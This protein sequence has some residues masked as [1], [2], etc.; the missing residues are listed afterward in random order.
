MEKSSL[1]RRT[2]IRW[3]LL[4][5]FF[6]LCAY[7]F[8]PIV[9]AYGRDL[10][11]S[12]TMIGL[13]GGAY[14]LTMMFLR[15]PTGLISDRLGK[16]R[17]FIIG[18]AVSAM[19][20]SAAVLIHPSPATLFICRAFCGLHASAWVPFTVLYAASYSPSESSRAMAVLGAVYSGAQ[21]ASMLIGGIIADSFGYS[22]PFIL[23]LAGGVAFLI[24]SPM[25][26]DT[27]KSEKPV[28]ATEKPA[29][30]SKG[31]FLTARLVILTLASVIF[32]YVKYATA[33]TFTPLIAKDLGASSAALGYLS[34]LY[35][36]CGIIGSA[37][38]YKLAKRLGAGRV[39][40]ASL[41]IL[42]VF[43]CF[44]VP[45]LTSLPILYITIGIS[46]LFTFLLDAL[47]AGI[48]I[49]GVDE[50]H[51][52]TTMGFYQ[53]LYGM[54]ILLGPVISGRIIDLTSMPVAYNITGVIALVCAAVVFIYDRREKIPC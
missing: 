47:L 11:A 2:M 44:I 22:A 42:A 31:S 5:L 19:L 21:L 16:R 7:P 27:P 18:G 8:V 33:Y 1:D 41:V 10:G 24:C 28:P 23:A 26:H 9:S 32:Y 52:T 6:W 25:M 17:I 36:A 54:G 15:F 12:D 50:S 43:S 3:F 14:G 40:V 20:A 37:I 29:E 13:I 4:T 45:H 49:Y 48:V 30:K 38:S 53:A 34:S 51:R 46:G 39:I 35:C